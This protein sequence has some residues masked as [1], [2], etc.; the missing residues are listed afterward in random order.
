[1][2]PHDFTQRRIWLT[3]ASSGIGYALA[4]ALINEGARIAVSARNTDKLNELVALAPD[5]VHSIPF[6]IMQKEQHRQAC[7]AVVAALGG[8]DILIMNAGDCH[9][10][11]V[12]QFRAETVEY[13]QKIN[14][15]SMAYTL[16]EALPVLRRSETPHCVAMSS[17]AA[18]VGL[19]RAEAYG[20]SKA[21]IKYFFD[22]LRLDLLDEGIRVSV[23]YPGFVK[24]PLTDKNDFPMPMLME[25]DKA[26]AKMDAG[27]KKGKQEIRTPALFVG[28]LRF[29]AVLPLRIRLLALK[30]LVR[31]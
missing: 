28:I 16:E 3:G 31:K 9:Y 21:S 24:T 23:I 19:P 7:D 25:V 10:I 29:I 13:M 20:G 22:S 17:N 26:A 14:F 11:D 15:L 6:D 1:M 27:I 5:R 2:K 4:N 12:K 30:S 8:I 18:Y